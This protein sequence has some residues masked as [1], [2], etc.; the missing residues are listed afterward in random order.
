MAIT[1]T[2][3][4]GRK[5]R[6]NV[7]DNTPDE[8]IQEFAL[9]EFQR[10]DMMMAED[11]RRIEKEQGRM[12]EQTAGDMSGGKQLLSGIGSGLTNV[13]RRATAFVLPESL[14]PEFASDEAIAEQSRLDAPLAETGMGKTGQVVGEI[15]AT[16]PLGAVGNLG[17]GAGLLGRTAA[18]AAE[19]AL[20]GHVTSGD[21]GTGAAFGAGFAAGAP[22]AGRAL[23]RFFGLADDTAEA[24]AQR[25]AAEA[26]GPGAP[27]TPDP[28][29]VT[30]QQVAQQ[31]AQ[32]TAETLP[33]VAQALPGAAE[34]A[35]SEGQRA[36]LDWAQRAGME[37]TPGM[38]TGS[39]VAQQA[40]AALESSPITSRP[41]NQIK[42]R[43]QR[44]ANNIV[45][46]A[47]GLGDDVSDLN[48][49]NLGRAR[50]RLGA[51]FEEAKDARPRWDGVDPLEQLSRAD[52]IIKNASSEIDDLRTIIPKQVDRFLNAAARGNL[53]GENLFSIRSAVSKKMSDAN[54][55]ALERDALESFREQID[56]LLA[57]GVP[58]ELGQ[59]LADARGRYRV[60]KLLESP[61]VINAADGNVSIKSLGNALSAKD[62]TGYFYG[63]NTTDLYNLARFGKAFPTIADSGTAT[64]MSLKE[65]NNPVSLVSALASRMGG[66]LASN[67]YLRGGE[68]ALQ[69]GSGAQ[70][71]LG[72]ALNA[73]RRVPVG[74]PGVILNQNDD[75]Y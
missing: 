11:R 46:R 19:G 75:E 28:N 22:A 58:E 3:P 44:R 41:F 42:E 10:Q 65:L 54:L 71:A 61:G 25:A 12:N 40:E 8:A 55:G 51:V 21:A 52:D 47:L 17:R 67:A 73:A 24:G 53:T 13:A 4:D 27:Q 69:A 18:G 56:N 32:Q 68:A 50:E 23:R 29:M 72:G 70:R 2:A 5:L 35:V 14:T 45:A 1:V 43:N 7:P 34:G 62:K 33:Q 36:A 31:T 66:N 60:L 39:K 64:R 20:S 16:L 48:S 59:R 74:T 49:E 26:P 15:A 57:D 9:K 38:R 6:L 37:T 63:R 30:P